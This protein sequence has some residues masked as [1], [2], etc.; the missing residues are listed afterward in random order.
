MPGHGAYASD[1]VCEDGGPGSETFHGNYGLCTFGHDCDDCGI[2]Y[3]HPAM[4]PTA[5]PPSPPLSPPLPPGGVCDND[6][7]GGNGQHYD[8]DGSCNDGGP[9]SEYSSCMLGHDCA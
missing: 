7:Y 1:G 2:R 8:N 6:C 5:P 9:G 3:L 4:P